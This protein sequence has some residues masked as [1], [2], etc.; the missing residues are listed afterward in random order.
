MYTQY[1]HVVRGTTYKS[2]EFPRSWIFSWLLQRSST[3]EQTYKDSWLGGESTNFDR[4]DFFASPPTDYLTFSRTPAQWL[5]VEHLWTSTSQPPTCPLWTQQN[6]LLLVVLVR[7][8]ALSL[9][10]LPTRTRH[11]GDFLSAVFSQNTNGSH[12]FTH[13]SDISWDLFPTRVRM[14]KYQLIKDTSGWWM[15]GQ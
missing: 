8:A 3:R 15:S 5:F 13:T 12:R 11:F 6:F 9:R 14:C 1:Q 7:A 4:N 2:Y 10:H